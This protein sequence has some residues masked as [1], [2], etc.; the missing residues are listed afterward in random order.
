M[1]ISDYEHLFFLQLLDTLYDWNYALMAKCK[2]T[3]LC[4]YFVND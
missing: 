2:G 1:I 4:N 3:L